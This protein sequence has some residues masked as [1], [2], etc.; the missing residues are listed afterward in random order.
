VQE[1]LA[2]QPKVKQFDFNESQIFGKI[3]SFCR[4]LQKLVDMFTVILQFSGLVGKGIAELDQML[5]KFQQVVED[6]RRLTIAAP[7]V[8]VSGSRT[9]CLTS[10]PHLSI[11]TSS[12]STCKYLRLRPR[13]SASSTSAS[14]TLRAR[15]KR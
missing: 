1:K 7:Y 5:N 10:L 2:L 4:R 15:S 11:A 14:K 12:S 3:N 13:S 6:M 9:I 8:D